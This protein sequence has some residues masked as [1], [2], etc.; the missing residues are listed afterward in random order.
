MTTAVEESTSIEDLEFH[1][2][3]SVPCCVRGCA[4]DGE[5]RFV[6]RRCELEFLPWCEPHLDEEQRA[7]AGLWE[8]GCSGCLHFTPGSDWRDLFRLVPIGGA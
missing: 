3:E 7:L 8:V 6:C 1:A 2:E 5:W 4:L